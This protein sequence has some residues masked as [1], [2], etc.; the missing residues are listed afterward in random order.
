MARVELR[1]NLTPGSAEVFVRIKRKD[2]IYGRPT[3]TVDTGA[4]V[5]L[6]PRS[7][8]GEIEQISIVQ[9]FIPIEQAG[10]AQQF[11]KLFGLID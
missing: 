1:I 4:A 5:S 6:F 3:A 8:L 10:I 9:T 11:P 2:H 7:A